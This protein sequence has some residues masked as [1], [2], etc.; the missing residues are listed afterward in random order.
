[1]VLKFFCCVFGCGVDALAIRKSWMTR[2][3]AGVPA[4]LIELLNSREVAAAFEGGGEEYVH[5]LES[6]G[7]IHH[8]FAQREDVG[9]IVE[10][11][12]AGRFQIPAEAAADAA[13]AV[14]GDGFAIA[15]AAEDDAALEP[16]RSHG[17]GDGAD[18]A[19]VIDGLG[20]VGAEVFHF[21][22]G[23]KEVLEDGLLIEKACV[24]GTDGDF[25]GG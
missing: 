14:G 21:M 9:V 8:A 19:G 10:A 22:S 13:N 1:L 3:Q 16:A 17:F 6:G 12:E 18:E 4:S 11:G 25:H 24:I 15:G 20:G 7:E 2:L 23:G 5:D